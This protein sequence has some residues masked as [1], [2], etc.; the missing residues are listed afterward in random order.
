M[1]RWL[2]GGLKSSYPSQGGRHGRGSGVPAGGVH[3]RKGVRWEEGFKAG[4]GCRGVFHKAK[5]KGIPEQQEQSRGGGTDGVHKS[6]WLVTA[7]SEGEM[8][9]G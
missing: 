8:N 4:E 3:I 9:P 5:G 6:P 1:N 7:Q 2:A